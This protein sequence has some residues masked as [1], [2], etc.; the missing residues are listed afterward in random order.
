M[1]SGRHRDMRPHPSCERGQAIVLI[2]LTLAVLVGM[3]ALAID[4]SRAYGLRRDLQAAVDA[5]ALT[6]GDNLQ[7]NGSYPTA[8]QAAATIFGT[9]LRLYTAPSCSPGYGAPT[10]GGAAWTVTCTYADGTTLTEVVSALGPQGSQFSFSATRSLKLQFAKILTNGA[11]PT[12]GALGTSSVNNLLYSP[13]IAALDTAGCSGAGSAITVG[14]NGTLDIRGDVVSNGIIAVGSPTVTVSGDVYANC[15]AALP[16]SMAPDCFPSDTPTPCT[17][18]NIAGAV[19]AGYRIADPNFPPPSVTGGSQPSPTNDP[20]ILPG[21]YAADP[22]LDD[23]QCWFLAGG[24]YQWTSGIF[25][26]Q[27]FLSNELKPPAEPTPG[28]NTVKAAHQFWDTDNQNC[29]GDFQ[30]NAIGGSA[31]RTGSWSIELTS[32]RTDTYN[33]V[34]YFRESAPS[35]CQTVA[36]GPSQII[37]V[38][39]SNIPGAT[40][41]NVYAALPGS[42]CAGPFGLAG[43]IPVSGAVTN[44][45]VAGCP[46]YSSG[47]CSLGFESASYDALLLGPL[48]APTGAAADMIGASPPDS[49]TSPLGG[50][51]V[52]QNA[53][54]SA[55][56]RGDRAN[57]NQCDTVAGAAA[58]CPAAITPG[59][60]EFYMPS[61]GCLTLQQNGDM[62]IFSGYQYDWV[63]FYEP[64]LGHPPANACANDYDAASNSSFIG[65]WYT[66][67]ASISIQTRFSG[68]TESTGGFIVKDISFASKQ[69]LIISSKDY[70]PVPPASRLVA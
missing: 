46:S 2:A 43:S 11:T 33:G 69:P 19:R 64:G 5:A 15:Q 6:A 59:A 38:Q 68:R 24:V 60:V 9:D 25:D 10:P 70:G 65:L 37:Q 29:E 49:E 18:P 3:A 63:A 12:L 44:D 8:E 31:I 32:T 55:P 58:S 27:D 61:G 20:V 23:G 50:R 4:G 30:L 39:V 66:P 13:A 28:N 56:P 57:E 51:V 34:S 40:G 35:Y 21:S 36:V 1:R 62:F 7:H 53:A 52:N 67:Q 17:A 47:S 45:D 16:G 54:R 14:G 26:N 42:G 48:F 41:Y 22:R